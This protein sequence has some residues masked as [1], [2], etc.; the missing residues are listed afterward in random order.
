MSHTVGSFP[1]AALAATL[2][3]FVP[4]IVIVLDRVWRAAR[5]IQL[6]TRDAVPATKGIADNI[7]QIA[8]LD[9]TIETT[10]RMV[11]IVSALEHRLRAAAKS[12]A[13]R[14]DR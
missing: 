10:A 6:N 12:P 11:G 5:S 14:P 2:T 9:Q 7:A 4:V 3:L 8:L 13:E 1:A